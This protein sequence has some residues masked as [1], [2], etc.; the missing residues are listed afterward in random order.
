[1][2][3][4]ISHRMEAGG[5]MRLHGY[6]VRFNEATNLGSFLEI[7]DP[8]AFT[9]TRME[10]VRF[11]VNHG[12]IPLA[13]TTSKTLQL[14]VDA[15]GL[16]FTASLPDTEAAFELYRAV[17][18]GDV[19]GASFGFTIA[20]EEWDVSEGVRRILGVADLFEISAVAFP[21]YPT[22]SVAPL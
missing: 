16:H 11:M 12:G 15:A 22:T 21:A 14:G 6:A 8:A 20:S 1:M 10:D 13:R 3:T 2:T 17:E 5:N 7:V 9:Y 18:R 4:R 19:T